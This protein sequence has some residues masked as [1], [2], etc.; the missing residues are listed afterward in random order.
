[1]AFGNSVLKEGLIVL[2]SKSAHSQE[3]WLLWKYPGGQWDIGKSGRESCAKLP[4]QRRKE[5]VQRGAP[6]Y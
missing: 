5:D 6:R 1:M 2:M 3:S 4:A